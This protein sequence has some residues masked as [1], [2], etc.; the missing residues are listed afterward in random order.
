MNDS[1]AVILTRGAGAGKARVEEMRPASAA[2][3]EGLGFGMAVIVYAVRG[4][5]TIGCGVTR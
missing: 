2:R 3:R 1:M 4:A 5:G